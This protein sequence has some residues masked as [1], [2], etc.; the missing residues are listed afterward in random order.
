MVSS[1]SEKLL[2]DGFV[3]VPSMLSKTDVADY[4]GLL[5]KAFQEPPVPAYGDNP[6]VRI[7][8]L[9]RFDWLADLFF[10]DNEQK[11][12]HELLGERYVLFPDSSIMDSQ[13][14]D[15]H[16]DTTSSELAGQ[17]FRRNADFGLTNIVFY[18]Q[19]NDQYGLS[20]IHI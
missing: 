17:T 15:W 14:G 18:F 12:L 9:S 8:V 3:I 19:D 4:R 13:Y 20:L 16:T 10:R 7:A 6:A 11:T 1:V 5:D 2:E